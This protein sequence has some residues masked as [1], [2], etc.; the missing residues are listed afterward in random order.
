MDQFPE[1][2]QTFLQLFFFKRLT[3]Y[4]I[5][6]LVYR[7]LLVSGLKVDIKSEIE[8]DNATLFK[9]GFHEEA[10]LFYIEDRHPAEFF[11]SEPYYPSR[12]Y[13]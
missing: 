2:V 3:M 6:L 13:D 9:R 1:F 10:P 5:L 8:F 12:M 7:L 11:W 4:I